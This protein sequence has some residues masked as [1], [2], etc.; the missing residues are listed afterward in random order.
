M[1]LLIVSVQDVSR[2]C[3]AAARTMHRFPLRITF[4]SSALKQVSLLLVLVSTECVPLPPRNRHHLV[5]KLPKLPLLEQC[6]ASRQAAARSLCAWMQFTSWKLV[7]RSQGI[8]RNVAS[9]HA[10]E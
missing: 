4:L 10:M 9:P 6:A 1:A 3:S 5:A 2:K 8:V 7:I